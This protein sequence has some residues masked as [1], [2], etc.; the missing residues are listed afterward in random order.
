MSPTPIL[1]TTLLAVALL[2]ACGGNSEE[3]PKR[4]ATLEGVWQQTG[5]GA[6]TQVEALA[7]GHWRLT[8]YEQ[9]GGA[10]LR[11]AASTE[12]S[13]GELSQM[14]ILSADGQSMEE[15]I[16]GQQLTLGIPAQRLAVLPSS[17]TT[18]RHKT[19]EEDGY[20]AD[21]QRDFDWVWHSFNELY[22]DFRLSGSNWQQAKALRARLRANSSPEELF[23]V[24][25][26]LVAPLGDGH[27]QVW[28][29]E[30]M[31]VSTRKAILPHILED[32]KLQQLGWSRPLDR[33]QRMA[34]KAHVDEV[35]QAMQAA[36]F[37][38]RAQT[39]EIKLRGNHQLAWQHGAD[40][41][42]YVLLRGLANFSAEDDN[43]K[44]MPA[45]QSAMD[46]LMQDAQ[47]ARGLIMD[48]RFNLGGNDEAAVSIAS[49]FAPGRLQ[50][51]ATQARSGA[52]RTPLRKV[53]LDPKGQTTYSGPVAVLTSPTTISAGELLALSMRALPQAR[54]IGEAS[55]GALSSALVRRTPSGLRFTLSNEFLLSPDGDWFEGQ[56]VPVQ[57]PQPF[58]TPELLALKHDP[59][60]ARAQ[61][62]L[63][64]GS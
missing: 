40:G 64:S 4:P 8:R 6:V 26:E 20:Q 57:L 5:Y 10:C 56:G 11:S 41:I 2:S 54:L 55:A 16:P 42:V 15:R 7:G 62:W 3:K 50:A 43:S 58:L 51:Y 30:R 63:I 61:R 32:Q 59:G 36:A 35:I 24:L 19:A 53:F 23:Q 47:G 13:G 45:L 14:L 9:A 31:F 49:R 52:Q 21:S 17:C 29:G 12:L 33:A 27:A 60:V 44:E 46:E 18:A 37:R 48:L 38:T 39:S 1:I 25:S 34:V 28:H 22:H